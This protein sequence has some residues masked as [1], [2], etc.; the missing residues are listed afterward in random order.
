MENIDK[1]LGMGWLP[2]Y[3][4][5]RDYTVEHEKIAPIIQRTAFSPWN[6]IVAFLK[7]ILGE[8]FWG[9]GDVIY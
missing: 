9:N 2:D 4:D 8:Y 5:Y 3:P 1:R 7:I 6:S